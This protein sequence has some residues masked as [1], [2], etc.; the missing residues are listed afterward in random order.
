LE[1]LLEVQHI[2]VV[3]A[4]DIHVLVSG[5]VEFLQGDI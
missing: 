5:G 2:G 3:D 1:G 4:D